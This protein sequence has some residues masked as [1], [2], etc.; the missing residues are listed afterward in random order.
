[1]IIKIISTPD[2]KFGKSE[3]HRFGKKPQITTDKY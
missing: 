2:G 3:I 1:M